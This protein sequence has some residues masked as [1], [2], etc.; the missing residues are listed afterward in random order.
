MG[1]SVPRRPSQSRIRMRRA[2][3]SIDL[4]ANLADVG[5]DTDVQ[6][7]IPTIRLIWRPPKR[8]GG[9]ADRRRALLYG[10]LYIEERKGRRGLRLSRPPGPAARRRY[11]AI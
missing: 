8:M 4:L 10:A 3:D 11:D 2:I 1:D 7:P 9:S 6:R 5:A